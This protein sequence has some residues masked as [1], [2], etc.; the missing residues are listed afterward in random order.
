[1]GIPTP[2]WGNE[3]LFAVPCNMF[4]CKDGHVYL[5]ILLDAH[6]K[7]LARLMGREDLAEDPNY[8]VL[9]NRLQRRDE[10]NAL[11]AAWTAEQTVDVVVDTLVEGGLTVAP[12]R[13]PHQAAKDPHILARDMLQDT[14]QLDGSSA[15]IV[16]PAAKFFSD[17][18]SRSDP[19]PPLLGQIM[20]TSCRG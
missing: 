12:V 15:P 7:I 17:P 14:Q 19:V 3:F 10:V 9:A 5:G 16:G 1:M 8:V 11:V 2:R 4:E 6:W 13:T 18:D 20:M